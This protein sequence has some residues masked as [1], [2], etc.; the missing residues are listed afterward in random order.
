[1]DDLDEK[2]IRKGVEDIKRVSPKYLAPILEHAQLED[3]PDIKDLWII[4]LANAMDPNFNDENRYAFIE[5]VKN[6]T[7][8]DATMLN[9][10]YSTLER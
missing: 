10:F 4:L 1:M 2:L 6:I 5:M 7:S 9:L 3:D 8:T